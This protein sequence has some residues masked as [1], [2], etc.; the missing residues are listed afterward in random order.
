MA[1]YPANLRVSA[2]FT[3]ECRLL[4]L[5]DAFVKA[6][7]P[8]KNLR[9]AALAALAATEL[10]VLL[11]A[12]ARPAYG[13][14]D[15]GSGL[16]AL[17]VGGSMLAGALFIVRARIRKLLG[18]PMPERPSDDAEDSAAPEAPEE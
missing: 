13:Y 1:P 17:Q 8:V 6:G 10:L 11:A 14:V 18:L 7:T 12:F 9:R 3:A 16:L 4:R 5:K 2:T 15:P